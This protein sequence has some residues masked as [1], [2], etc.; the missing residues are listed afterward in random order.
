MTITLPKHDDRK[1]GRPFWCDLVDRGI[2]AAIAK[3]KPP[4]VERVLATAGLLPWTPYRVEAR[5]Y[6]IKML[7]AAK[8][9]GDLTPHVRSLIAIAVDEER[10]TMKKHATTKPK[11]EKPPA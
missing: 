11:K 2:N 8:E 3:G 6:T 1:N 5:T 10:K 4:N 7:E 9:R